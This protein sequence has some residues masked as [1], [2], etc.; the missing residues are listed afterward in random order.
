[1]NNDTYYKLANHPLL[2]VLAEFRFAEI[3]GIE[4]YLSDIQEEIRHIF[5]LVDEQ[6]VQEV[7]ITPGGMNVNQTK[8]WAFIDKSKN[9]AVI[10]N[11]KRLVFITSN[12][13]RFDGFKKHCEISLEALIKVAQPTILTRIGLR[14]ADLITVKNEDDITQFV[15]SNICDQSHFNGVG[16][17]ILQN[18]EAVL[19]T[20][21]GS[22]VIRSMYGKTDTSIFHDIGNLPIKI[23]TQNE[24][25]ERILLDFDHFWQLNL[26][27]STL[28]NDNNSLDFE[29]Q[30][31]IEKLDRM[32][33]LS[34]KAFWD[35]TTDSGREVWK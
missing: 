10:I 20:A 5:P 25:S 16:S 11:N 29:T 13:Q 18:N 21:E 24:P 3:M 33:E 31:I 15:K 30:T 1:M 27:S 23:A 32:H 8:Q 19:D 7:N 34:R 2:F 4:K 17:P 22:M 9:N 12:Y 28:E 14:Y 26:D 6:T 35:I